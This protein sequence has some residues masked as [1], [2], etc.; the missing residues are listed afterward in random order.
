MSK[1]PN[2]KLSPS[3]KI[4]TL[5]KSSVKTNIGR[6]PPNLDIRD[7][8]RL[9]E[10]PSRPRAINSPGNLNLAKLTN[11]CKSNK[12]ENTPLQIIPNE[13][14][15]TKPLSPTQR[16]CIGNLKKSVSNVKRKL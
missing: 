5:K 2:V 6:I 9:A 1:K 11:L 7:E 3:V 16:R 8:N 10:L 12:T 4:M 15:R 14:G 13:Q